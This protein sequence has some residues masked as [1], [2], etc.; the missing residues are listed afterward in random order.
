MVYWNLEGFSDAP[1]PSKSIAYTVLLLAST[2][3][4]LQRKSVMI[5]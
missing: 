4:F 5:S 3:M 2:P 1:R